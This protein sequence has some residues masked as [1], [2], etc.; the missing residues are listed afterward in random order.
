MIKPQ[1]KKNEKKKKRTKKKYKIN[2]TTNFKMAVNSCLS[3]ITVN[4]NGPNAPVKA[5]LLK[6]QTSFKKI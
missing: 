2:W 3:I 5:Q 6:T 1:K 4:G